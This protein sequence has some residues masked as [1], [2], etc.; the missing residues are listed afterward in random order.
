MTPAGPVINREIAELRGDAT[1]G[2]EEGCNAKPYSDSIC[3]VSCV[4][5]EYWG[6]KPYFTDI[7]CAMELL[8]EMPVGT[9]LQKATK[10]RWHVGHL[11]IDS[12]GS[13]VQKTAAAA[14]SVAWLKWKGE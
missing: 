13:G 10:G 4:T 11:V 2:Y 14:A 5:C 9:F 8:D 6:I 12:F 7:A 3:G 1:Y